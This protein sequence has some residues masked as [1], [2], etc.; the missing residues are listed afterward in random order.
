PIFSL[1]VCLKGPRG[2]VTRVAFWTLIARTRADL[3]DLIDRHND[4]NAYERAKMLAWTQAQIQLR[5]LE[6]AVAEAADFQ[7]LAAPII[8]A[9]ARFRAP[10]EAIRRGAGGQPGRWPHSISG[11]L[12]IVLLRIDASEDITQVQQ[13]LR[14]HEYWR[15]KLLAVDLVIINERASSYVQ[16]LQIA[17]DTAVR[18]SQSRPRFGAV[19]AQ[20]SVYALRA[21]LMS[22]EARMLIQSV[23]RVELV[24][25]RGPLSRQL[26]Y[27]LERPAKLST[28]QKPPLK[29]AQEYSQTQPEPALDS[30]SLEFF[31]CL[32]GFDK[33]GKEYVTILSRGAKTPAPWINVIANPGFGFQVSTE[34]SGYT[35]AD[36]SRENQLTPWSNDPVT[37]PAGEAIYV[38]DEITGDL[39]GPTAQ[40]IRDGGI[41]VARHGFGYSRFE[42]EANGIVLDLLQFVPLADPVKISRLTL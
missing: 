26:A 30:N 39:W 17:I 20:G 28:R 37:D 7:R 27:Q 8:Y 33:N 41:Y 36:N 1:R 23:A 40:P 13:L 29:S 18:I 35:W 15:S 19:S 16:D 38:R 4:R 9:D 10:P 12:P 14:A 21:D 2:G 32:G 6:I 11:D 24:A 31:K 3:L 5:H 25:H 22:A 42:H 34:G